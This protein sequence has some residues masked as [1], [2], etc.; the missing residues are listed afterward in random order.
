MSLG[1]DKLH[2]LPHHRPKRVEVEPGVEV[3][4]GPMPQQG[5]GETDGKPGEYG[6]W[7]GDVTEKRQGCFDQ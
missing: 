2:I 3:G 7:L 5:Q 4:Q 1:S 6:E